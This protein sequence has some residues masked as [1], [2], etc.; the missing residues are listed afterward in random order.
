MNPEEQLKQQSI[1]TPVPEPVQTIQPIQPTQQIVAQPISQPVTQPAQQIVAQPTSQ[2]VT[3]PAQQVV[4]QPN[5][6][7][8]QQ[9]VTQ[10]ATPMQ[11]PTVQ[12]ATPVQQQTVQA[13]TPVEQPVSK[14]LVITAS[15]DEVPPPTPAP[16][17]PAQPMEE[18][19]PE[20]KPIP[21]VAAPPKKLNRLVKGSLVIAT[22]SLIISIGLGTYTILELNR[23]NTVITNSKQAEID[24]KAQEE[25]ELEE[26]K[27]KIKENS[28]CSYAK[29]PEDC[30]EEYCECLYYDEYFEEHTITCQ[31]D[32]L[33]E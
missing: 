19:M 10:P 14:P 24:K 28:P 7:P 20:L 1:Q 22:L 18:K 2:P 31:K 16:V 25:Q 13:A 27:L 9:P 4:A 21:M 17:H 12:P 8:I 11:Q 32:L 23:L 5:P 15:L 3:Q 33:S 26:F 29:C 6:Q 30:E